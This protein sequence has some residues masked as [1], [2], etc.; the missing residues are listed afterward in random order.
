[1]TERGCPPDTYWMF[2]DR[3]EPLDERDREDQRADE[4]DGFYD[5]MEDQ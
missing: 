1:M 3:E 4:M 2:D 5:D